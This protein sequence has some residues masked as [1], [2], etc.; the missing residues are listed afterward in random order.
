V[1]GAE[2]KT[3]ASAAGLPLVIAGERWLQPAET[4]GPTWT[5]INSV[6]GSGYCS[7]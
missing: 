5:E 7:A 2:V 6:C 1:S 3:S 4:Y